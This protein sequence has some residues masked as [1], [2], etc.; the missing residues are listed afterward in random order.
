MT[1][2]LKQMQPTHRIELAKEQLSSYKWQ[3]NK[4]IN[5][6]QGDKEKLLQNLMGLLDAYSPLKIMDRGYAIV[7]RDDQIIN[8]ARLLKM[9]DP[10]KIRM[11]H[12]VVY[13]RVES[14]DSKIEEE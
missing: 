9:E 12:G 5:S 1:A 4:A 8:D 14:V 3:L 10:L 6:V 13:S 2:R 11:R 7:S